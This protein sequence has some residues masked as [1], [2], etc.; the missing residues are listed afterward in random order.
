MPGRLRVRKVVSPHGPMLGAAFLA[1][2]LSA[3][4]ASAVAQQAAVI[5]DG[6]VEYEENMPRMSWP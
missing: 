2:V 5:A 4:S 6:R 3:D 1:A